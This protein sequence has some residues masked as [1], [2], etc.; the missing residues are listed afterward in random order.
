MQIK[1][2]DEN[3]TPFGFLPLELSQKSKDILADAQTNKYILTN[4]VGQ[5]ISYSTKK[6]KVFINLMHILG[7]FFNQHGIIVRYPRLNDQQAKE[8]LTELTPD[9]IRQITTA[10]RARNEKSSKPQHH[11]G[12]ISLGNSSGFSSHF[13]ETTKIHKVINDETFDWFMKN[14]G[15]HK[16]LSREVFNDLIK[17]AQSG[18]IKARNKIIE[19][20]QKLIVSIAKK[21]HH[22]PCFDLMDLVQEGNFGL[23]EAIEKFD[24]SLGF[25]FSTYATQWIRQKIQRTIQ[26]LGSI[27]RLPVHIQEDLIKLRKVHHKLSQELGREPTEEE[28]VVHTAE[29]GNLRILVDL[30][31]TQMNSLDESVSDE[32]E[33]SSTISD[34][35][36][37]PIDA[38]PHQLLE[39]KEILESKIDEISHFIST[40]KSLKIDDRDKSMFAMYYQL[41]GDEIYTFYSIGSKFDLSRERIRQIVNRIWR[42]LK[43]NKCPMDELKLTANIESY[44]ELQD[45]T[46]KSIP[47]M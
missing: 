37:D 12:T 21:Y 43:I 27:I 13:Y 11:S 19:H 38:S 3:L 7:N 1:P 25:A 44:L 5:I 22:N 26:D 42:L 47:L 6:G 10:T 36:L 16:I 14:G 30:T 15:K 20:N 41:D 35:I 39:A 29:I 31:H 34:F 23:I 24:F 8:G 45:L 40:V 28:L 32:D 2:I 9:K 4:Q 46:R 17:A 18:D 33:S